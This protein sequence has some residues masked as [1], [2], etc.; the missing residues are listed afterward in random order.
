MRRSEG[1]VV[2][3]LVRWVLVPAGLVTLATCTLVEDTCACT[4]IAPGV[5][6]AGV[7]TDST[8]ATL[9]GV[10]VTLTIEDSSC[11]RSLALP[12]SAATD[13]LGYYALHQDGVPEGTEVCAEMEA[14]RFLSTAVDTVRV[15]GVALTSGIFDPHRV[16]LVFPWR[17]GG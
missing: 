1:A 14:L 10:S 16:D 9:A 3:G 2:G 13:S 12:A 17:P 7:V 4:R 8:G 11:T 6:V 5:S 15:T